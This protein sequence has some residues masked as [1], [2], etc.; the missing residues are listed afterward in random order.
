[1]GWGING[2]SGGGDTYNNYTNMCTTIMYI[3]HLQNISTEKRRFLSN[4]EEETIYKLKIPFLNN[5][6]GQRFKNKN[7]SI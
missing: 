7:W 3:N 5:Q 1:M 4:S 2:G 6:T